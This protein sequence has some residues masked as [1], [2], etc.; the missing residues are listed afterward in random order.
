M[1]WSVPDNIL[2]DREKEVTFG[3]GNLS[4]VMLH[5]PNLRGHLS[6]KHASVRFNE[7]TAAWEIIDLQVGTF[8]STLQ[9][10]SV[11]VCF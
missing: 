8:Y 1:E 7:G 11:C 3:R 6:R 4:T 5:S 9:L 2:L 10:I